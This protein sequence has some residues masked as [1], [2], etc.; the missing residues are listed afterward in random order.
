MIFKRFELMS[1]FLR[2][3]VGYTSHVREVI[4]SLILLIFLGGVTISQVENIGLGD[5]SYFAFITAFSIGYGDISPETAIGK[6]VSV[7][8][9][10][11][12]MLFVG[13]TVAIATRAL[14][15]VSRHE[16]NGR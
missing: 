3:F 2:A 5:A 11:V 14:A 4:V 1:E 15:E 12:G 13:I 6:M 10:L 16:S 7:A 9:G 8:I